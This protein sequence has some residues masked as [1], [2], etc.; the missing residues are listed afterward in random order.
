MT[1]IVGR[2]K[3]YEGVFLLFGLVLWGAHMLLVDPTIGRFGLVGGIGPL[4]IPAVVLITTSVVLSIINKTFSIETYLGVAFLALA[5]YTLPIMLEGTTYFSYTFK[6]IGHVQFIN[7]FGTIDQIGLPYQNWPGV[8]LIGTFVSLSS[9]SDPLLVLFVFPLIIKS[10][11]ISLI[12]LMTDKWTGRRDL[13]LIGVLFF[14]LYDWTAYY[15]FLPPALGFFFFLFLLYVV[16]KWQIEGQREPAMVITFIIGIA[17]MIASHVLSAALFFAIITLL[18][19]FEYKPWRKINGETTV[20][21]GLM[22]LAIVIMANFILS[23]NLHYMQIFLPGIIKSIGNLS[24]VF[25]SLTNLFAGDYSIAIII[26]ISIAVLV[27]LIILI[28][29]LY[30]MKNKSQSGNRILLPI[31]GIFCG[32]IIPIIIFSSY[33]IESITRSYAFIIPFMILLLTA[34][35]NRRIAVL[36]L[37]ALLVGPALFVAAAYGNIQM[38]HV[39]MEEVQGVGFYYENSNIRTDLYSYEQGVILS[40]SIEQYRYRA[41]KEINGRMNWEVADKPSYVILSERDIARYEYLTSSNENGE[42]AT[43][44]DGWW[45]SKVYDSPDFKLYRNLQ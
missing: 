4:F 29:L 7:Q 5:L 30:T 15:L 33:A 23:Y 35:W 28:G 1:R 12:F 31:F 26:K 8:M 36:V 34:V 20:S 37:V 14:I 32:G 25:G 6:V 9:S 18:F 3:G 27:G 45:A 10:C 2:T 19:L 17:A 11:Q 44:L 22:V 13:S 43:K 24:M 42:L 38:D 40:H 16:I 39:S 41:I 21:P